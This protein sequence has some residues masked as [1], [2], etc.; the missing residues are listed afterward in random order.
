VYDFDGV[1]ENDFIGKV[2]TTLGAVMG[3]THQTLLLDITDDN[4]KKSG[5]II[6]RADKV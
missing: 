1:T 3:A 6:I 5:K 4:S 2:E